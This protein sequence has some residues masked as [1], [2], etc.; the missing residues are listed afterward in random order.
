[1]FSSY[2]I[3]Q[4]SISKTADRPSSEDGVTAKVS[5]M[6]CLRVVNM[7][8]V[9]PLVPNYF[10]RHVPRH[11][12]I[13]RG[14]IS[15]FL[16]I[17]STLGIFGI[18]SIMA[19][20]QLYIHNHSSKGGISN[21][22]LQGISGTSEGN[23]IIFSASEGGDA[24]GISKGANPFVITTSFADSDSEQLNMQIHFDTDSIFFVC[25]NSTTGHICND[26]RNL[27]RAPFDKLTKASR[28][29]MKW[30]LVFKKV[31]LKFDSLT[32]R[33][34]SISSFWTT[35]SII[36]IFQLILSLRDILQRNSLMQM[37]IQ[38]RKLASSLDTQP[39]FLPGL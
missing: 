20:H 13:Y 35:V 39:T 25:N 1:M 26:F 7:D 22:L 11:H 14:H 31:L 36:Q 10:T 16:I 19:C 17:I 32:M 29:Q 30:V 2:K 4:T 15:S 34:H 28:L 37:A 6:K 27:S 12:I 33:K 21:A 3:C 23:A 18:L 24:F 9:C 8:L 38:T 5:E